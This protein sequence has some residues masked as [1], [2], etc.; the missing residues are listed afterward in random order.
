MEV[1]DPD[2]GELEGDAEAA[3]EVEDSLAG[4]ALPDAVVLD[5]TDVEAALLVEE[6]APL[7]GDEVLLVEEDTLLVDR[8]FIEAEIVSAAELVLPLD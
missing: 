4:V 6:E 3:E 2:T 7:V 5:A 8:V 1:A